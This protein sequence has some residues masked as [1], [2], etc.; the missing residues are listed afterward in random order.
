MYRQFLSQKD[1][2]IRLYTINIVFLDWNLYLNTLELYEISGFFKT[3]W[4]RWRTI[5]YSYFN[6]RENLYILF[7]FFYWRSQDSHLNPFENYS[8]FKCLLFLH[9]WLVWRFWLKSLCDVSFLFDEIP[10]ILVGSSLP[11]TGCMKT[12]SRTTCWV[13][14][15]RILE[16]GFLLS[17][18]KKTCYKKDSFLRQVKYYI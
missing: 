18:T 4:S 10:L 7:Y 15:E 13:D 6:F 16:R 12:V 3:Q 9:S 14:D 17:S 2:L 1:N 11:I 5:P 8:V